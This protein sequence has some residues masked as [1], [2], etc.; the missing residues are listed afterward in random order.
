MWRGLG[1]LTREGL[2]NGV[3]P[4][5]SDSAAP[6]PSRSQLSTHPLPAAPAHL[7]GR[8][9]AGRAPSGRRLGLAGERRAR[10]PALFGLGRRR[11]RP[12]GQATGEGRSPGSWPAAA[13][14]GPAGDSAAAS[15]CSALLSSPRA[16]AR[17]RAP[18]PSWLG[19][20]SGLRR[21]PPKLL[22]KARAAAL[23]R[24]RQRAETPPGGS[25]RARGAGR[26]PCRGHGPGRQRSGGLRTLSSCKEGTY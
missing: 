8:S 24:P 17:P 6:H 23:I 4:A 21:G 3:A 9:L 19:T 10:P 15:G 22:Y 7:L 5:P 26:G 14:S 1:L 20:V 11:G 13:G 2:P 16:C 25:R 18:L 12:L